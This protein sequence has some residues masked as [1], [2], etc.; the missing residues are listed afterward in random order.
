M[1]AATFPIDQ[2]DFAPVATR[3]DA[4]SSPD[5]VAKAMQALTFSVVGHYSVPPFPDHVPAARR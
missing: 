2:H 3:V 4:V 1:S 5:L